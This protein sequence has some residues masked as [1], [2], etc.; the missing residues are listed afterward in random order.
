MSCIEFLFPFTNNIINN[1]IH[2]VTK[3]RDRVD[4]TRWP[5]DPKKYIIMACD[6]L[7][8]LGLQYFECN[9]RS[10][11]KKQHCKRK[12]KQISYTV[13]SYIPI[14]E[15]FLI[16]EIIPTTIIENY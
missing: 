1:L 2:V 7:P 8:Y 9:G 6:W 3:G 14:N 4:G 5:G 13:Q 16:N 15:G 10:H 11:S 12:T